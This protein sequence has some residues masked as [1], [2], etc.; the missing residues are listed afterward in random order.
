MLLF[1]RKLYKVLGEEE[2]H[3]PDGL[4]RSKPKVCVTPSS[5]SVRCAS[6]LCS[7]CVILLFSFSVAVGVLGSG[8]F[9][10][11]NAD[12]GDAF[13]VGGFD[14]EGLDLLD[15]VVFGPR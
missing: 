10:S 8:A 4:R 14:G 11:A 15:N 1:N 9:L 3:E 7:S 6:I 5:W 13:A 2:Q 12:L